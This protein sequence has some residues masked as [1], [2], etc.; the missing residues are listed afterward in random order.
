MDLVRSHLILKQNIKIKLNFTSVICVPK[1][2][3]LLPVSLLNP[4]PW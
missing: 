4:I 1:S 2:S 3:L